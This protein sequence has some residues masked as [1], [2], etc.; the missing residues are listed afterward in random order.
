MCVF[1]TDSLGV[2]R[3]QAPSSEEV[4]CPQP[5]RADHDSRDHDSCDIDETQ[6]VTD[7]IL[8]LPPVAQPLRK[9]K[10]P[11]VVFVLWDAEAT[12]LQLSCFPRGS[13]ICCTFTLT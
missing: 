9:I 1:L 6:A 7:Q 3:L 13:T 11:Q 5:G 12:G 8:R 4:T 2:V 10:T